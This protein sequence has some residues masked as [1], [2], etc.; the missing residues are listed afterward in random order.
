MGDGE[1]ADIDHCFAEG[2]FDDAVAHADDKEEEK[3]ERVAAGV[4]DG[5]NYQHNFCQ[6]IG[7]VVVLVVIEAPSHEIFDN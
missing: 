3:G 4:E 2:R 5:D 1:E 7:A 6:G